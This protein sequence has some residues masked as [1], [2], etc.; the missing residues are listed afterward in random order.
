MTQLNRYIEHMKFGIEG[1]RLV[2][3]WPLGLDA[4]GGRLRGVAEPVDT[5]LFLNG[6]ESEETYE[7]L[8]QIAARTCYLHATLAAA[9]EP[10]LSIELNGSDVL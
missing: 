6:R 2:Q 8:M 5:H 3:Y 10:Q 9:L 4:D 7:R 1:V